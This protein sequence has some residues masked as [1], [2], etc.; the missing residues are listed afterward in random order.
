M[1]TLRNLRRPPAGDRGG[2]AA[3]ETALVLPL[4]FL[5]VM[6]LIEFGRAFMVAQL[7]TNAAREGAREA[8]TAG[9]TTT[10]IVNKVKLLA[11][12]SIGV[13]Q[14]KFNV[15]VQVNGTAA[16]LSTAEKRDMCEVEVTVAIADVSFLPTKYL[17]G[18][19]VRGQAAMRHE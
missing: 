5:V 16:D 17:T 2:A 18:S 10:A 15:S 3:V 14:S 12:D 4:F 11:S 6:G 8:I 7:L 9:S 19:N 1:L 13:S